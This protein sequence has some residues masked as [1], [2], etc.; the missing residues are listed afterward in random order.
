MRNDR[1]ILLKIIRCFENMFAPELSGE[2]QEKKYQDKEHKFIPLST[3]LFVEQVSIVQMIRKTRN[4]HNGRY[5]D[6]GYRNEDLVKFVD[7]G[8]GVGTKLVIADGVW[9]NTSSWGLNLTGIEN[10]PAYVR[11]AKRLM[12]R[13]NSS[14][15]TRDIQ[16]NKHSR[17][18]IV[19]EDIKTFDYSPFDIIYFYCPLTDGENQRRLEERIIQT[20]KPGAYILANLYHL[21]YQKRDDVEVVWKQG[22]R[23]EFECY[24]IARKR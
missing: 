16:R 15:Y 21:D 14:Y 23:N 1:D 6:D 5:T 3:G 22:E 10:T 11:V 2:Q 20:A 17:G 18:S 9:R 19:K 12:S 8:C 24:I 7:V 13:Y 4:E